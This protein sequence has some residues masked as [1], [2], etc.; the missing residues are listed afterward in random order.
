MPDIPSLAGQQPGFITLQLV[1]FREGLRDVP[2]M[3]AAVEG[4]SDSELEDLSA[5]FAALPHAAP[6]DRAQRRA[7][8]YDNGAA[9]VTQLR[10]G[11]C[12]LPGLTGQ[13]Q[14]PH[15]AGQ[16][17]DFLVA[18]LRAYRDDRRQGSDTQMNGVMRGLNDSDIDAIAHYLSQ[19]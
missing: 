14:V 10:C 11:I 4:L 18:T 6:P 7:A 1:L 5:H 3:V 16:R 19:R 2:A 9:L 17:E 8:L 13:N 12:H 15:I